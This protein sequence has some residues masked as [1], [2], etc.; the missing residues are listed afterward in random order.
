MR[1]CVC[2]FIDGCD[3]KMCVILLMVV[4]QRYAELDNLSAMHF[5]VVY[6][7]SVSH[8]AVVW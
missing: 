1:V 2:Y 6:S 7:V 4:T 8:L 5:S 3:T